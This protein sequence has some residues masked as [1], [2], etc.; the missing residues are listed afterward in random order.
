VDAPAPRRGFRRQT[1]VILFAGDGN[2]IRL[3]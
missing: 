3:V 1:D 2:C